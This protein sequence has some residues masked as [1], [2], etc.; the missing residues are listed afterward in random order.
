MFDGS[1]AIKQVVSTYKL[2]DFLAA[3]LDDSW[4]P[5]HDDEAWLNDNPKAV[6][7][8]DMAYTPSRGDIIWTDF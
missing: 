7:G 6:R 3:S 1:I 2:D 4:A 5:D 8:Y